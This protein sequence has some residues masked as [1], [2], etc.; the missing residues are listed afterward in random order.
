MTRYEDIINVAVVNFRAVWGDKASNLA[1]I[2]GFIA[3]A[4][5]RGADVVCFPEMALTGYDNETNV[6]K[7]EKMQMRE[8]E[9]VPGPSTTEI[10]EIAKKYGIYVV[11]GM[12]ERD[13]DD[14][15]VLYNSAVACGPQGIIGSYRKIHPALEEP[16]WCSKGKEPFSFETPWGKIGVGICYDSYSFHEIIRYHAATGARLYLNPTAMCASPGFDWKAYYLQGLIQAVNAN[17]IFVAS[18]NLVGRE[19]IPENVGG[20]ISNMKFGSST[21]FTGASVI[22]GPGICEKIHTYAGSVDICE[23]DIFIATLDLTLASRNIFK[24]NPITGTTDYRP[25]VYFELNRRLLED[26]HW[27]QDK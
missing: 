7:S 2:K 1:R 16:C 4:A 5:K 9:V 12:P 11:F 3:A 26:P 18:S 27:R 22:L 23:E 6:P 21:L 15:T 17:E 20:S 10:G 19:Q 13:Q 8:A 24:I 14:P 25:D